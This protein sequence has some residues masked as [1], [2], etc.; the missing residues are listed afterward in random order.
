LLKEEFDFD[1]EKCCEK[2]GD[3]FN[4]VKFQNAD[5][6]VDDLWKKQVKKFESD[7][8]YNIK[9]KFEH[10][11]LERIIV[12]KDVLKDWALASVEDLKKKNGWKFL[13]KKDLETFKSFCN[14]TWRV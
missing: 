8:E 3:L 9:F 4:H 12:L 1:R 14:K 2:A 10:D 6:T 13:P 5:G 11:Q 7:K